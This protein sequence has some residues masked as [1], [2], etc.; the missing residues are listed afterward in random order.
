MYRLLLVLCCCLYAD[1]ASAIVF[2]RISNL[3]DLSLPAWSIGDPAVT[4]HED[5]C[6]YSTLAGNYAVNVSSPGGFF[7]LNGSYQLPYSLG[8][9]DGGAGHLGS[10]STPL[11]NNVTLQSQTNLNTLATDCSL[12]VPAG[13]TAR[14]NLTIMQ[15][16]MTAARAGTYTGTIT[17]I[18]SPI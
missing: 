15:A 13:A 11:S 12:G 8:W 18:I 3:S 6:V 17:L 2:Y 5:I 7:L 14:L 16:D 10:S 4:A 1:T 9:D